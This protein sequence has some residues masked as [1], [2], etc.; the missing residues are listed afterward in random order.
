MVCVGVC[1]YLKR[2]HKNSAC[3]HCEFMCRLQMTE[4]RWNKICDSDICCSKVDGMI[5]FLCSVVMSATWRVWWVRWDRTLWMLAAILRLMEWCVHL[6]HG[7]V[8]F[9]LKVLVWQHTLI[10]TEP[11]LRWKSENLGQFLHA[12]ERACVLLWFFFC[13]VS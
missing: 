1:V 10:H 13:L 12:C 5:Y 7:S 4:K 3:I 6:S 11:V 8:Q 9:K 2:F